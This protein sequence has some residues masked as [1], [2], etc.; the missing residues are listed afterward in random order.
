MPIVLPFLLLVQDPEASPPPP[1]DW[2]E[3]LGIEE[4]KRD[5]VTGAVPVDPYVENNANA[6]AS[7]V[8]SDDLA[9]DFGGQAGIRQMT[10]R[11]IAI[12]QADPRIAAIF[13][14]HDMVRLRRTLF[15]QFCYILAAGCDYTGR[16]MRA[17]HKDMGLQVNDMNAL[18]ENL[19]HAMREQGIPFAS[20][21]RLL[22][23]LAPM[24]GDVLKR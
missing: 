2:A 5:P 6:G 4:E 24:R 17:A 15:E 19:R 10:D 12:N 7:P 21:N 16:D 20:Q 9:S 14:G 13:E 22:G 3:A 8:R 1:V 23:K 11:L 18:V